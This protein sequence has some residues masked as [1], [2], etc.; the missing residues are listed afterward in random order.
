MKML[1]VFVPFLFVS[2]FLVFYYFH[3]QK[4]GGGMIDPAGIIAVAEK[5]LMLTAFGLMMIVV[6]LVYILLFAFAYRYR[7]GNKH[8]KY[9]PN[10]HESKVLEI[11]WWL[12]PG[13]IVFLL[14]IITWKS[15]HDLDPY[16]PLVSDKKP[17]TVQVVALNWKWLFIYPEEQ[18]ATVNFLYIPKDVPINFRITA[19]A[20]MNSFW[21]PE[22]GGQIYAMGGMTTQLHLM[23]NKEGDFN[24][25]SANFSGDGFGGMKFVTRVGSPSSYVAWLQEVRG[26]PYALTEAEY[27]KLRKP[28]SYDSKAYYAFAQPG[29]F[30]KIV[31]RYMLPS[32]TADALGERKRVHSH[33]HD[34]TE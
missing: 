8:A 30:Q 13:V 26:S 3:I 20:P 7:A 9:D 6:T 2:S 27:E 19:D 11:I 24:G 28:T 29:M 14:A 16:K 18:I 1:K 31:D 23:G 25:L 15:T 4:Y 17:I 5:N 10:F 34:K 32:N 22:L 33:R 12:I 21:I